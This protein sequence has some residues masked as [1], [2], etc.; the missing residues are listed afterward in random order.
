MKELIPEQSERF[1]N[2]LSHVSAV[3]KIPNTLSVSVNFNL[4]P[5]HEGISYDQ[6]GIGIRKTIDGIFD[7]ADLNNLGLDDIMD[8]LACADR[9]LDIELDKEAESGGKWIFGSETTYLDKQVRVSKKEL[10]SL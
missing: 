8:F 9:R 5:V 6:G 4:V 7:N 3:G 1:Q 10:K 2:L